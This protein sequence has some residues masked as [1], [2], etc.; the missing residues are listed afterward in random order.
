M[1]TVGDRLNI[2]NIDPVNNHDADV[3]KNKLEI[4]RSYHPIKKLN[5]SSTD[6][7]PAFWFFRL[8]ELL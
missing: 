5:Q 1:N 7:A 6:I 8:L 2:S 4:A 3:V